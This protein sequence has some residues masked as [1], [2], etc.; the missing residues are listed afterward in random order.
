MLLSTSVGF[1][2]YIY[3]ICCTVTLSSEG[4][5][6]SPLV[7]LFFGVG[8]AGVVDVPGTLVSAEGCYL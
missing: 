3:Y 4:R 7:F 6:C 5:F 2:A 1:M 8:L